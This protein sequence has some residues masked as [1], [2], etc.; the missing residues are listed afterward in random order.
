MSATVLVPTYLAKA[1]YEV[2]QQAGLN[3]I[4][5]PNVDNATLLKYQDE[6]AGAIMGVSPIDDQTYAQ[7]KQ[8][9]ILARI[10]VGFD[11][12]N[13][14]EAAKHGIVVTITPHSNAISV[15][16]ST[17]GALLNLS[18]ALPQRT[19]LM[20]AGKWREANQ[21]QGHDIDGKVIGII[22]YGRIGHEV[23]KR[24]AALG[25][26]VL[27][28]NGNRPKVPEIGAPVA[29]DEL[30]EKSDYIT[31]S[32]RVTAETT[33]LINATTLAK[34]KDT[35]SIINFGRGA[36]VDTD[37]LIEALKTGVI[38]SAALDVFEEEPLPTSSELYK[39]DNVLLSP[40]I[41]GGTIEAMDRGSWGAA[42][43]VVRVLA[44][45]EPR[46]AV[47]R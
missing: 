6:A 16:E 23:E 29:L 20:R 31:L 37:A 25:M 19:A 3:I 39:L 12:L 8:L 35:A 21:A 14:V 33:H 18:K 11:S 45:Q 47:R 5:V 43:E 2:L 17:I 13:P 27:I 15:A 36:L 42:T 32:T 28:N 10:G 38:H 1:G 41:G 22:G 24:A 26:R 44:G 46:W 4:E 30:L 34:M 9:K 40:H 7:M